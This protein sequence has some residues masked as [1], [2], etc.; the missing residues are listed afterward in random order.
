M[1]IHIDTFLDGNK[2]LPFLVSHRKVSYR[3]IYLL[4]AHQTEENFLFFKIIQIITG[5][6]TSAVTE[7]IGKVLS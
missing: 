2:V 1:S 7:L 4:V 3:N 5:I 6:P